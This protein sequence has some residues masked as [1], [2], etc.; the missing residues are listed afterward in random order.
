MHKM[1]HFS[2]WT[3]H[4]ILIISFTNLQKLR[5]K[6]KINEGK[7]ADKFNFPVTNFSNELKTYFQ[8][9]RDSSFYSVTL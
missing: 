1:F 4:T 6:D 5:D 7:E 3:N 8:S 2:S 9:L